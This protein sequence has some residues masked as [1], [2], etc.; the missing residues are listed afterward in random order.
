MNFTKH[1]LKLNATSHATEKLQDAFAM[2]TDSLPDH[3]ILSGKKVLIIKVNDEQDLQII[4]KALQR[5]GLDKFAMNSEVTVNEVE[6]DDMGKTPEFWSNI[7][8]LASIAEAGR[9]LANAANL[10]STTVDDILLMSVA[11][12]NRILNGKA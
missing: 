5:A 4:D 9:A 2:I 8:K 10:N 11:H 7:E 12:A 3:I 6:L 1:A